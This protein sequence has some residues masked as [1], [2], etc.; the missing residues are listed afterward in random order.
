MAYNEYL[1]DRIRFILGKNVHV[2][3]KKMFGGLVFLYQGKMAAG[4]MGEE[5]FVRVLASKINQ[6]LSK[7]GVRVTMMK[8]KAMKEFISLSE[9]AYDLDEDLSNFVQLGLEHAK[10]NV[11]EN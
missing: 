3:E 9:E 2:E 4:V 5:I 1:A 11:E 8:D 6:Q 10:S 7:P